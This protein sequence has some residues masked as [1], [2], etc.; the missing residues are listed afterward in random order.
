M[1]FGTPSLAIDLKKLAVGKS[2]EQDFTPN[3]T[4][5]NRGFSLDSIGMNVASTCF[6]GRGTSDE[7][8]WCAMTLW[9]AMKEGDIYALCPLLPSR[10]QSSSTMLPFLSTQAVSN[11]AS[12]QEGSLD[13]EEWHRLN[14][15]YQ[16]IAD[17]DS[18]EPQSAKGNHDLLPGAEVYCRPI[19]PGSVPKLQGPFQIFGDDYENDP[20]ISDIHII[21]AKIDIEELMNG[22]DTDT[23]SGLGLDDENGLSASIVCLVS[24]TGRVYISL[25]IDGVQAQWLPRKRQMSFSYADE[26]SLVLCEILDTLDPG[27]SEDPEW[28]TFSPDVNSRYSFLITHNQGVYYFSLETWI[29]T[30]QSELQST[31]S[32]GTAF[33]MEIITNGP[34]TLR[35]QIL[36]FQNDQDTIH[37]SPTAAVVLQ[38]SDLGYFLLTAVNG[39]PYAVLLDKPEVA[40]EDDLGIQTTYQPAQEMGLDPVGPPRQ[41]Y[42]P[43]ASLWA[44]SVLPQFFDNHVQ[45]R[46]K[47]AMR[48]EI[49]LSSVTLDLMTQAHRVLSEETHTLG[50][51]A[52]DL[53]RRC[54]RLIDELRG[55]IERVKD[56]AQRTDDFLNDQGDGAGKDERPKNSVEERIRD[57]QARQGRINDRYD[58]LS[59]D[60]RKYNC[61]PLSKQ[62]RTFAAEIDKIN[63]SVLKPNDK[64]PDVEEEQEK[65]EG[66]EEGQEVEEEQA[67]E[68]HHTEIWYRYDEV[69]M[70]TYLLDH[71]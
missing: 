33:R 14:D 17:L 11:Q 53:F 56:I 12:M 7:S 66:K 37:H 10:W 71:R 21:A 64:K 32:V 30:L 52:A 44:N 58:K 8:P 18:Q 1:S 45:N 42:A 38:D 34:G 48:E 29:H 5:A 63:A 68:K 13:S 62:E 51:A 61:K 35:E 49:R 54:E 41:P 2:V 36:D 31:A 50:M 47:R 23:D 27:Y 25:D 70:G 20:E 4:N 57:A 69:R 24:K 46:H 26:P 39:A 59:R 22:E 67:D 19:N 55:Q 43:P 65:E 60:L 6:G 28:P 9:V 15:Q 3:R 16:W 40:M